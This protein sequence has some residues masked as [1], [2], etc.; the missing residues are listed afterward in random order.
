MLLHLIDLP[1]EFTTGV[2][3][4][5]KRLDFSTAVTGIPVTVTANTE[6]HL[7]VACDGTSGA[8]SYASQASFFRGLT[9]LHHALQAGET[10]HT[11]ESAAFNEAGLMVDMSRNA[12]LTQSG[13]E[14]MLALSAQLGLNSALLYMEDVY[15]VPEYPYWGYQRGRL[16]QEELQAVDDFGAALGIE[17]IPCIQTL[18]HLANPMRWPFMNQIRDTNGILLVDEPKTY[19]FLKTIIQAATAPFRTNKVHIGMDEAHELGRGVYLDRHGLVDRT[20]IMLR[21]VRRL[22]AITQELNLHPIMWSDMWFEAAGYGYYDPQVQFSQTLKEQIPDVD[23]M[24]WDYYHEDQMIYDQLIAKHKELG[25][26]VSLATGCWTWNGIAPNYG[27][28]L[29]TMNAGM[30]AAKQA[31]L[32]T[33]YATMWGDDGGE[34]PFTSAVLAIQNF[35]EQVY[36]DTVSANELS[37]A[38]TRYQDKDAADYLALND[39]DQLPELTPGNPEATNPSK[40]VLYEDLLSPLFAANTESVD[41]L[42]HYRQLAKTL[43]GIEQ[44]PMTDPYQQHVFAFYTQ[45]AQVLVLKL[46]MMADIRRA[47]DDGNQQRM[48]EAIAAL[49]GLRSALQSLRDA[50]RAC[51]FDLASP[52]GWEVMDIRY[53]GLLS[54]IDTVQWRLQHWVEG[55]I[56]KIAELD[57]PQLLLGEVNKNSVMRGLYADIVTVSKISGV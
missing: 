21:H 50:H 43:A 5:A 9:A 14:D 10:L 8:I 39:F 20:E 4:M 51:W 29:N 16:S 25:R 7:V 54:R 12:S 49:T 27:K 24:Y 22:T 32:D 46:T 23:L 44:K 56:E 47:Y 53:G 37:A 11:D 17:V 42:G 52:F 41:L 36:H 15:A 45:L 13:V 34:T 40:F 38:F 48:T 6:N 31:Q 26:P 18:A 19:E 1:A 35:A 55:A 3:I 2:E 57:E 30:A 33:V 28:A